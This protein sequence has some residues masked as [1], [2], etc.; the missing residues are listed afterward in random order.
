[1]YLDNELIDVEHLCCLAHARAKFK[2]AYD[3]GS[4]QARIFLELIARLYGMEETYRREKL[5]ADEIYRRRNC[6]E[7]TEIID[8]IRTELYDLLANP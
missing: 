1:M 8:K 4:L 7:T 5:T 6:K 2:Y 3:Q